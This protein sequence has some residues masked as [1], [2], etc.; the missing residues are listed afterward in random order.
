M[1]LDPKTRCTWAMN[2]TRLGENDGSV[3]DRRFFTCKDGCGLFV[4]TKCAVKA[5][6]AGLEM[7]T[8]KDDNIHNV[9]S[10]ENTVQASSKR[11][12]LCKKI[13]PSPG[14]ERIPGTFK[15]Q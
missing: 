12:G 14:E 7:T 3:G 8:K 15:K 1:S 9:V 2:W 4:R 5:R 11:K 10:Y 13:R 6:K